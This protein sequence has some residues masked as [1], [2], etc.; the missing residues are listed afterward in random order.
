[1]GDGTIIDRWGSLTTLT[2]NYETT[3]GNF[4]TGDWPIYPS[5]ASIIIS[6]L[7]GT[8]DGTGTIEVTAHTMQLTH[9]SA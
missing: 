9:R 2:I 3:Q 5:G 6:A 4:L 1:V 7:G 8:F